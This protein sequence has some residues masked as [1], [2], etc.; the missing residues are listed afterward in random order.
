M[1]GWTCRVCNTKCHADTIGPHYI[2]AHPE[3]VLEHFKPLARLT[4]PDAPYKGH[5]GFYLCLCCKQYHSSEASA[6]K[7]LQKC[8]A[9]QQIEAIYTLVGQRPTA[10]TVVVKAEAPMSDAVLINMLH[11]EKSTTTALQ[12][13]IN[14]LKRQMTSK[15]LRAKAYKEWAEKDRYI[16]VSLERERYETL[17]NRLQQDGGNRWQDHIRFTAALKADHDDVDR[18]AALR[19]SYESYKRDEVPSVLEITPPVLE[20][21]PAPIS[22]PPSPPPVFIGRP[23]S[24]PARGTYCEGCS[25]EADPIDLRPCSQCHHIFHKDDGITGCYLFDCAGNDCGNSIC[26]ICR[27]ANYP[28]GGLESKMSPKCAKCL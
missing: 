11:A 14:R 27:K 20:V 19:L 1:V 8:T 2:K 10:T 24:P 9:A 21:T 18:L 26:D 4:H 3:Y 25:R 15:S 13:E 16:A 6:K 12:N 17:C 7:H 23:P 28:K 22:R 5:H